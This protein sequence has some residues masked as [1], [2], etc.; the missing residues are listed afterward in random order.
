MR[1]FQLRLA[2]LVLAVIGSLSQ[3]VMA[4]ADKGAANAS[5]Q[6]QTTERTLAIL[7]FDGVQIIDYTGP[8]ETFG[9]A[10]K[11]DGGAINIY[12]V[13]EKGSAITTSMGMSVNPTYSFENAPQPDILVLPG[14]GGVWPQLDN[15]NVIKWV[16][17]KAKN[18][19]VVMSVCNGA[20][21][22]AKAGLLDGLQA[23]TTFSL[24]AKLKEAAPKT[25]VVDD[26]RYVDNGKFI[27]TAGLSSG[28]EGSL[29]L[30]ERLYGK[31]MAQM[32]AVGME[33]NWQPDS[34]YVRASLAER[35]MPF[36]YEYRVIEDGWQPVLRDG[37]TDRLESKW[38]VPAESAAKFLESINTV[39]ANNKEYGG[40]AMVK[41]SKLNVE[42]AKSKT[43]SLW[44]FTDEKGS[45]WNG[46]ARVE[47]VTG[48]QNRFMFS[49]KIARTGASARVSS[50]KR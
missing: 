29:H 11:K 31:G 16:Q 23:T 34:T 12:T 26:V 28:I 44:Q 8:Y 13:A 37:N 39:I 45:V 47:P 40:L 14:G 35:Y 3:T 10:F 50:I 48:E 1:R 43:Q 22:L 24:I 4:Q 5:P 41:W 42:A 20:F 15:P 27:T 25:R 9:H 38:I 7:L 6:S 2:L 36:R 46:T 18:A 17:D 32:A 33:Y 19:E 21:F 30:I 49:V